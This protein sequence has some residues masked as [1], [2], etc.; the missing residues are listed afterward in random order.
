MDLFLSKAYS[1][2]RNLEVLDL[3]YN[4]LES[5][6]LVQGTSLTC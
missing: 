4:D 2:L 1:S 3:S 5:F 6:Q